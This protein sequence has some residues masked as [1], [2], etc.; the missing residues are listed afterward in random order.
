[1][2][3]VASRM[4][5]EVVVEKILQKLVFLKIW[6][7]YQETTFNRVTLTVKKRIQEF[8]YKRPPREVFIK[9]VVL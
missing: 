2:K 8:Q 7:S 5:T 9:I 1:M 6:K 3:Q 4:L